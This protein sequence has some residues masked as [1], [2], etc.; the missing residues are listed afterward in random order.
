MIVLFQNILFLKELLACNGCF[1]LFT[2]ILKR[3]GNSFQCTF[4]ARFSYKNVLYL[5]LHLSTYFQC[6]TFLVSQDIEQNVPLSSYFETLRLIYNHPLKQWLKGTK[7]GKDGNTKIWIS[8]DQKEFFQWN[9]KHFSLFL[10]GYHLLK[11]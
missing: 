9:K 1:R 10:K 11:K 4:S 3:S 7:R 8:W 6:H 2:K 5:I